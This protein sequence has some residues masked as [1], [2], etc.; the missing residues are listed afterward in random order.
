[1]SD[2]LTPI[3]SLLTHHLNLITRIREV[4]EMARKPKRDMTMEQL[5][6]PGRWTCPF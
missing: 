2:E 4:Q 6:P 1:M 5:W 3:S